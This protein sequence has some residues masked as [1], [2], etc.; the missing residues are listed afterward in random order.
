MGEGFMRRRALGFCGRGSRRGARVDQEVEGPR[1]AS[2]RTVDRAREGGGGRRRLTGSA[3]S[4]PRWRRRGAFVAATLAG[5]GKKKEAGREEEEGGAAEW[6]ADG[7]RVH[8]SKRDGFGLRGAHRSDE[9]IE[10]ERAN[11]SD[12]PEEV[13]RRWNS[14]AAAGG[15]RKGKSPRGDEDSIKGGGSIS[16]VQGTHFRGRM[17]LSGAVEVRRREAA[18]GGGRQWRWGHA[19]WRRSLGRRLRAF[20]RVTELPR[21]LEG[22]RVSREGELEGGTTEPGRRGDEQPTA[23]KRVLRRRAGEGEEDG[24]PESRVTRPRTHRLPRCSA[25]DDGGASRAEATLAREET[26]LVGGQGGAVKEDLAAGRPWSRQ[27]QAVTPMRTTQ[28][29]LGLD[30]AATGRLRGAGA[31]GLT[32]AMTGRGGVRSRA[33]QAAQARQGGM[34]GCVA[35]AARADAA[36]TRQSATHGR[37]PSVPTTATPDRAR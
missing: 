11:G 4:K 10:K 25:T 16:G 18:S 24:R 21:K 14:T 23:R 34:G 12:S 2:W 1:A 26:D 9:G 35:Q 5:G 33:A 13:R 17:G 3:R 8:R 27:W 20:G 22:T 37:E 30:V 19:G 7:G 29:T 15:E 32:A 6:T 36:A 28:A 31:A